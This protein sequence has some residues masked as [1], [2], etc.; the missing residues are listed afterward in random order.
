MIWEDSGIDVFVILYLDVILP[1]FSQLRG[2]FSQRVLPY[3]L[4]RHS[5]SAHLW[6]I[7]G[8]KLLFFLYIVLGTLIHG[9]LVWFYDRSACSM[10]A[11]ELNT[12]EVFESTPLRGKVFILLKRFLICILTEERTMHLRR[13]SIYKVVETSLG[14]QF[15]AIFVILGYSISSR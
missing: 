6:E 14:I 8:N 11:W 5:A 1:P 12:S 7:E 2:I 9:Q 13:R 10:S 15:R 4:G 3:L